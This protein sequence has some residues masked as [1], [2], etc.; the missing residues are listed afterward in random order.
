MKN[1][2]LLVFITIAFILMISCSNTPASKVTVI[3]AEWNQIQNTYSNLGQ[4]LNYT[5][6]VQNMDLAAVKGYVKLSISFYD[7]SS[8]D[9]K[10]NFPNVDA[11]N[12]ATISDSMDVN[13][14]RVT[15][16][17]VEEINFT[18]K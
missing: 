10:V 2:K 13:N 16:V 1:L 15:D 3:K 14:K 12:T 17:S 6:E 4:Q 11:F 5:V 18:Y 7:N 9:E 8:T